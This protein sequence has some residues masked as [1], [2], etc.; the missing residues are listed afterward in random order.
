MPFEPDAVIWRALLGACRI[1]K[2]VEVAEE[3][4]TKLRVLNPHADGHY[5]LLSNIYAQANAWE[6]VAEM[7]KMIRRKSIQR[8]PGRSSI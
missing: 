5:V 4:M 8:I 1:H 7:R 6:G 2:N 3:A